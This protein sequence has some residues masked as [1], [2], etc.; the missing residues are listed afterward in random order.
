MTLLSALEQ[1][2]LE[3][4]HRCDDPRLP[5]RGIPVQL[6]LRRH[7]AC[8]HNQPPGLS[9]I[10]QAPLNH[11]RDVVPVLL[12][13]GQKPNAENAGDMHN[14]VYHT[15]PPNKFQFQTDVMLT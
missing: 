2:R 1:V 5:T 7:H 12:L 4:R 14:G 13:T 8:A 15:A 11:G 6:Q 10:H 3:K 9:A